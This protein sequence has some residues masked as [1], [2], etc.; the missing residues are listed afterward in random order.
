MGMGRKKF[1][2]WIADRLVASGDSPNDDFIAKLRALG[3]AKWSYDARHLSEVASVLKERF[4]NLTVGDTIKL[5]VGVCDAI[6]RVEREKD[7]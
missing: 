5:A 3:D 2:E 7:E 4:S 1:L 6:Q